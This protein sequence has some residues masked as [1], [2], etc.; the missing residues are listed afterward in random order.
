MKIANLPILDRPPRGGLFFY[1]SAL[2]Y[3]STSIDK[4]AWHHVS[5]ARESGR[6]D[7]PGPFYRS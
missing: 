5:A 3:S 2:N 6:L 7:V 4:S 1:D